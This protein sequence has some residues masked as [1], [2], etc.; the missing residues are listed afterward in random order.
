MKLTNNKIF[1]IDLGDLG[2]GGLTHNE[3]VEHYISNGSPAGFFLE[4][5]LTKHF[6][7][8]TYSKTREK[9]TEGEISVNIV[10]DHRGNDGSLYDQKTI[11]NKGASWIRSINKGG[12]RKFTHSPE[13]ELWVKS[14]SF[15]FTDIRKLPVVRIISIAGADLL[16]RFPKCKV[17]NKNIEE[18]FVEK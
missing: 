2:H 17:T 8:I 12:G 15:I 14:Q 18:L 10:P 6:S 13:H 5:V 7:N 1:T 16:T 4:K 9:I 11:T 3:M